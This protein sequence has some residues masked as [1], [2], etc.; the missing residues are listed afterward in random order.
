MSW[1][2]D[3]M[4]ENITL[5]KGKIGIALSG[6]GA[7][8]F[9]HVGVL[10]AFERFGKRPDIISGV[11][12][13]A[14]AGVLYASGLSPLEIIEC[15]ASKPKLGDFTEWSIPKSSF[16]RL[17]KFA[18]L[19]DNWLPVKNLEDLQI[20]TMV[21]ATDFDNG[22]SVGWSKGEIVPRVLASCSIPII[23]QPV[24]INGVHYVDGGVLRNMPA[25]TIRDHC[26][27]LYGSNCSP[28]NRSYRYK[29]SMLDIAMRSYTLMSKANMLQ[30]LN[31]CD[32]VI[33]TQETAKYKT[34]DLSSIR[35]LVTYGYDTA[36]RVLEK[37]N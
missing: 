22:K 21:C 23:F 7:R 9:A 17:T 37:S 26:S 28:L 35:K 24:R 31:L 10:M 8:G 36:C 27:V 18:K 3:G 34:F 30:D 19:L 12:A 32:Y 25:W 6:G 11:S 15:F 4:F 1:I 5:H 16:L 2:L 33:Q 20:P 29:N 13:G 14:I